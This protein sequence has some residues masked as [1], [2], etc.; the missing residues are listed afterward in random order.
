MCDLHWLI[1][2]NG[3][4]VLLLIETKIS[5]LRYMLYCTCRHMIIYI[6]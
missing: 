3:R 5:D 2:C 4:M 6:V 1:N